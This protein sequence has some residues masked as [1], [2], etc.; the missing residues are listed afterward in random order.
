MSILDRI[1]NM[2]SD[3]K[4]TAAVTALGA[5]GL[6]LIMLSSVLPEKQDATAGGTDRQIMEEADSYCRETERRLEE[7]LGGIEGAGEVR[8]YLAVGSNERYVYASEGKRSSTENRVEEE[9]KYVMT[10][11]GGEKKA[12]VE[13]I[14]TPEICG[15]VIAASGYGSPAVQERLYKAASAAL[16]I[17]TGKIYVTGLG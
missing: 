2:K 13:T 7:F 10:G 17:P 15:A 6:F 12:L 4:M 16:D 8:V 3:R 11:N 9:E 5:T 14:K 1:R